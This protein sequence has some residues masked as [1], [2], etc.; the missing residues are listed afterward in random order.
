MG[1]SSGINTLICYTGGHIYTEDGQILSC[2]EETDLIY[3]RNRYYSLSVGQFITEDPAKDGTNWYVYCRN[4]PI[5]FV[6]PLG[7]APYDH[8][9]SEDEAAADFGLYIGEKSFE[10]EEE[11]AAYIYEG[12]DQDNKKYYYDDDPRNDLPTHEER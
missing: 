1:E 10:L 12:V 2:D 7:L 9:S 4:N 8:F 5:K 3:L 6:D 11:L